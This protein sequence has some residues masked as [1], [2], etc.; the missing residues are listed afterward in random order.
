MEIVNTPYPGRAAMVSCVLVSVRSGDRG[1]LFFFLLQMCVDGNVDL[2]EK[3][4]GVGL[5]RLG[6]V[7]NQ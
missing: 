7:F 3:R 6:N 4:K 1:F 2:A 5:E